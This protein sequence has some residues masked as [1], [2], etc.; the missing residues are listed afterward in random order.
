MKQ[1]IHR[2][3]PH[4]TSTLYNNAQQIT[5]LPFC[6]DIPIIPENGA[7]DRAVKLE[8]VGEGWRFERCDGAFEVGE[9]AEAAG[10]IGRGGGRRNLASRDGEGVGDLVAVGDGSVEIGDGARKDIRLLTLEVKGGSSQTRCYDLEV[11]VCVG[12]AVKV[13]WWLRAWICRTGSDWVQ[14]ECSV[15]DETLDDG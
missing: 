9:D 5:V 13:P 15:A 4:D 3:L 10:L 14:V 2:R 1:S 12:L 7:G 6:I 11:T 8:F